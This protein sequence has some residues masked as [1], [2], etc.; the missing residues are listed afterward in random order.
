VD[1]SFSLW[2]LSIRSSASGQTVVEFLVATAIGLAM[3]AMVVSVTIATQRRYQFDLVRTSLNQNLRSA[4]DILGS[5]IRQSG[6]N[7]PSFFPAIEIINGDS[8]ASDE[9]VLRRNLGTALWVCQN[10]GDGSAASG[11]AGR[12]FL[13]DGAGS[14]AE[15]PLPAACLNRQQE[16]Q[17]DEWEQY[18]L[19]QD[20][21]VVDVF[22]YDPST[23]AGE[24]FQYSDEHDDE[25]STMYIGENNSWQHIYTGGGSSVYIMTEWH[26]RVADNTLQV[27]SNDHSAA[28]DILNVAFAVSNLQVRA[29][30]Q[31]GSVKDDFAPGEECT[32]I[33]SIEVTI[34]GEDTFR[35][36]QMERIYSARFF[37]RNILSN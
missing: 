2:K 4:L 26:Y 25:T 32:K 34:T 15:P 1:S 36:E 14:P 24:F 6:E 13:T 5:D 16:E 31:D 33:A 22:I 17:L 10:V 12:V 18:R 11:D 7:L 9:L 20:D 27:I 19:S 35:G 21:P 29:I 30:M 3:T 28:E 23:R 8:G 37:P